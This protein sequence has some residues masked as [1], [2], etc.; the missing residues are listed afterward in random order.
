MPKKNIRYT[1]HAVQRRLERNIT[2]QQINQTLDNPDY[3][4]SDE[5]KTVALRK[6]AEKTIKVVYIEKETYIKIITVY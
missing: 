2:D 1:K 3:T 6:I 4:I 5:G